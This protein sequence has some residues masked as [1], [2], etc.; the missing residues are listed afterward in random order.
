MRTATGR[1]SSAIHCNGWFC[2]SEVNHFG[3][4]LYTI[5]PQRT[6]A[7]RFLVHKLLINFICLNR[8]ST[9]CTQH[10]LHVILWQTEYLLPTNHES[11]SRKK[12][13]QQKAAPQQLHEWQDAG[14]ASSR[15]PL[16][17]EPQRQPRGWATTS[18]AC[19]DSQRKMESQTSS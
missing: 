14:G 15:S 16:S 9:L 7:D 2:L 5:F 19:I 11:I 18:D 13:A 8:R 17:Q 4:R 6:C 10:M 3:S 12:L 1:R